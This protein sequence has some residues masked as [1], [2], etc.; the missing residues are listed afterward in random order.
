MEVLPLF[1]TKIYKK[2]AKQLFPRISG[3]PA[4]AAAA[5]AVAG[6]R[7]AS[8]QAAFSLLRPVCSA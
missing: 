7:R 8:L 5:A 6:C 3:A 1:Y 2:H 4:A